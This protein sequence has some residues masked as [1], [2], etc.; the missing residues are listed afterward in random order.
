MKS[1]IHMAARSAAGAAQLE[2]VVLHPSMADSSPQ[3]LTA[4]G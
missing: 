2:G 4:D 3:T 1:T